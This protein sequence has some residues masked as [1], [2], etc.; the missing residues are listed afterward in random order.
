MRDGEELDGIWR[1]SRGHEVM[2]R[3]S[4]V[5]AER[6]LREANGYLPTGYDRGNAELREQGKT[7]LA[8]AQAVWAH[9]ERGTDV[10]EG[11]T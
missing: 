2:L 3:E 4:L 8:L 7:I 1:F 10:K 5:D 6:A 11:K 9:M